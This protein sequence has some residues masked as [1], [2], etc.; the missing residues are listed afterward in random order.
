MAINRYLKGIFKGIS[1]FLQGYDVT[2]I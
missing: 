2:S 1:Y